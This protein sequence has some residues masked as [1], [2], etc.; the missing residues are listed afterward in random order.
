MKNMQIIR[1]IFLPHAISNSPLIDPNPDN[2][3][4]NKILS[5]PYTK[6]DRHFVVEN[7][8]HDVYSTYI[9]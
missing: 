8:N 4:H 1:I 5:L 6:Y 7:L 2:L 9:V 3:I